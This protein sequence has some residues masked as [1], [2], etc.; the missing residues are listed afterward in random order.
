MLSVIRGTVLVACLAAIP[1]LADQVRDLVVAAQ[2][3]N[4]SFVKR[5]I[6]RGANP[7]TVDP[8]SGETVLMV[9]LREDSRRVIAELIKHPQIDLERKAPNGNRALMLAAYKRNRPAVEALIA[10]GAVITYP[11]WTPLHYAAASGDTAIASILLEHSAYIDA[12]SPSKLT[13]LMIAARE[14]QRDVAALLLREGADAR[15]LNNE[16]LSAA[17][18]ASRAGHDRIAAIIAEHLAAQPPR[19]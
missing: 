9:A 1:A 13:P 14:G 8:T 3:D 7:N 18:I 6:A 12:E 17:Q 10:R 15:L 19:R 5:L 2:T 11:G 4:A 16:R